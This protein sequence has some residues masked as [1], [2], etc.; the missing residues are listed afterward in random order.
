MY[1]FYNSIQ[2][3]ACR[4]SKIE[5]FV[6]NLIYKYKDLNT[7]LSHIDSEFH[8]QIKEIHQKTITS[9]A[10]TLNPKNNSEIKYQLPTTFYLHLTYKCNLRCIYCYNKE[11]RTDFSRLKRT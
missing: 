4:I 11:I 6:F 10:L 2:H 8:N 7:I 5:L 9:K 3:F 1:V